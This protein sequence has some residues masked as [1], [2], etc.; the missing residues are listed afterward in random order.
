MLYV[1]RRGGIEEQVVPALDIPFATI[2]A[3]KLD[4]E[5]PLRNWR[6]PIVLPQALWD[7]WR[8]TRRFRP[9]VVVGTGGYVSAPLIMVAAASRVPVV[10]Q[11][12]NYVPGRATRLLGR[13][14]RVI[15]IAYPQT[16]GLLDGA[17][18][19]LTGTPVREEFQALRTD[20]PDRPRHVLVLGGSQG[21]HRVNLAVAGAVPALLARPELTIA[22]QT[23]SQDLAAME[24]ARRTL[25]E[26]VRDRYQPFAF[27]DDLPRRLRA[28][29][30][31]VSRAGASTLSETSALGI[32]M[33]LVPGP[34][35]GG[36]QRL[37]A[38]PFAQANAAILVANDECDG[39][40]ITR[41]ILALVDDPARYRAMIDAM[42]GQ[43][44]PHAADD[45]VQ[46]LRQ[47]ARG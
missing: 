22:H 1:G 38:L 7:A 35:A 25:P 10:L 9:S 42:R 45:V 13:L 24:A 20:F 26:G 32:P 15:A 12:Q 33:I 5:A 40:R 14:A 39:P 36:H 28:A 27:A 47:V 41:E 16:A 3:V 6:V 18:T 46:I 8:V 17:R 37:N 29:D 23:G 19:V 30:L 34:F 11:E 21:A 43:S 4:R 2:A 31:V 44:R